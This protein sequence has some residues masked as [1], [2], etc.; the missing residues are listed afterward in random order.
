MDI[1]YAVMPAYNEEDN[2]KKVV[3][4]WYPV[5][6]GKD[7]RS[8]LVVADSESTDGTHRILEEMKKEYPRLEILSDTGKQHGPKVI[9]L[10]DYAVRQGADYV[11]QTDSAVQTI[12]SRR[13]VA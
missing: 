3:E 9:A 7:E 1:L 13:D 8:R 6:E 10:Y 12:E 4:E 2:I 11:F 5:L